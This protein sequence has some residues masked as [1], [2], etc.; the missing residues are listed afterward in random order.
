LAAY[1]TSGAVRLAA[2]FAAMLQM[3]LPASTLR[4]ALYD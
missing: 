2:P 1:K 3:V 4:Q